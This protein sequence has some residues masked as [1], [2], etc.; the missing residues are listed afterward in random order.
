[1]ASLGRGDSL[2][3]SCTSLC[4]P[5]SCRRGICYAREILKV[6]NNVMHREMRFRE[7]SVMHAKYCKFRSVDSD[8]PRDSHNC[9]ECP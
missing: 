6:E 9:Y 5:P 3:S 8:P 2:V 4:D 1:M 7:F